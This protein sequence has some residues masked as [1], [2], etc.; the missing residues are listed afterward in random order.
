MQGLS[1]KVVI[2][3]L[4]WLNS[5]S[6]AVQIATTKPNLDCRGITLSRDLNIFKDPSLFIGVQGLLYSDPEKGKEALWEESP[7]LTTV[8][9]RFQYMPFDPIEFRG[10]GEIAKLYERMEP[11][12]K[13]QAQ[14]SRQNGKGNH[15]YQ[16]TM[17]LPIKICG[18]EHSSYRDTIG[19]VL[20]SDLKEAQKPIELEDGSMPPSTYGNPIPKLKN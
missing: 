9:G 18:D 5:L 19:F 1:R 20:V 4:I 6:Q 13:P 10:F 14:A 8:T 12:L 3:S 17:I 7:L 11:R 2:L 16:P 15:L